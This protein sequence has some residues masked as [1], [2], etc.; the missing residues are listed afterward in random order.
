MVA[1]LVPHFDLPFKFQGDHALVVEQDSLD[2]VANCVEAVLL[3]R[4][5]QRP[6]APT[7][8]TP[9]FTFN[10]QPI[11]ADYVQDLIS[12]QEPRAHVLMTEAPDRYDNLIARVTIDLTTRGGGE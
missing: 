5:G 9:D 7:F 4:V 2:D 1:V 3:T 11:G 10:V 12:S 8:G 6:E